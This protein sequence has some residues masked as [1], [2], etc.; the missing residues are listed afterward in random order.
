MLA[1]LFL[2][3]RFREIYTRYYERHKTDVSCFF[4]YLEVL[5]DLYFK[6]VY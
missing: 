5:A 4:F 1:S 3:G 6:E 2:F